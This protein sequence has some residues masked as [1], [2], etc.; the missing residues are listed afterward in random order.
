MESSSIKKH[1]FWFFLLIF[2]NFPLF[3]DKKPQNPLLFE[4]FFN[5]N[6]AKKLRQLPKTH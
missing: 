6:G 2:A 3:F 4:H 1:F 5:E